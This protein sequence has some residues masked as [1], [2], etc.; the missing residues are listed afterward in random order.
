MFVV[1][2]VQYPAIQSVA[3]AWG[4]LIIAFEY[5]IPQ[6]KSWAIYRTH[7][8]RIILLVFQVFLGSLY[9]QVGKCDY[10]FS[11]QSNGPGYRVRTVQSGP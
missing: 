7:I 3:L 8:A 5:P 2:I 9:Y 4:I 11:C 1:L 10:G 6:L